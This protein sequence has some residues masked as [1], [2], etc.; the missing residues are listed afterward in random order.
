M[1]GADGGGGGGGNDDD[2]DSDDG[3][4]KGL[5]HDGRVSRLVPRAPNCN[6]PQAFARQAGEPD[7]PYG[8]QRRV[9][10]TQAEDAACRRALKTAVDP[11]AQPPHRGRPFV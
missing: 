11:G 4:G 8:I 3:D 6:K 7:R 2:D 9:S 5:L 1:G 10:G